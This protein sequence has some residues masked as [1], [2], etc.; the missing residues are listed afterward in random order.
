MIRREPTGD[1]AQRGFLDRER[2]SPA[3]SPSTFA[4]RESSCEAI[5]TESTI[6]MRARTAT[7][8]SRSRRALSALTTINDGKGAYASETSSLRRAE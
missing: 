1:D 7:D 5:S 8:E 2:L 6:P 3:A 4:A